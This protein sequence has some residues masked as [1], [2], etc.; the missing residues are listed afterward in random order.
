MASHSSVGAQKRQLGSVG[1]IALVVKREFIERVR[2]KWFIIST[3]LVP[4]FLGAMMFIPMFLST[5]S[6]TDALKIAVVDETG[7]LYQAIDAA[8]SS[9]PDEDFIKPKRGS[10]RASLEILRIA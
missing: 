5:M 6:S 8:L 4:V 9:E 10:R 2:T 3:I 7:S 1:K